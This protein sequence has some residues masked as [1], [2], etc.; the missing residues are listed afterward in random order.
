MDAIMARPLERHLQPYIQ[1][2]VRLVVLL[3]IQKSND[4]D[5]MH[6][7]AEMP[8][9]IQY[10]RERPPCEESPAVKAIPLSTPQALLPR[11]LGLLGA[12]AIGGTAATRLSAVCCV[13]LCTVVTAHSESSVMSEISKHIDVVRSENAERFWK[14]IGPCSRGLLKQLKP[15]FLGEMSRQV[16]VE[17]YGHGCPL[18]Q[19]WR[20]GAIA[21]DSIRSCQK[22]RGSGTK[23]CLRNTGHSLV[24]RIAR[25]RSI[26]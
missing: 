16:G 26:L 10:V 12:P 17:R 23:R 1:N 6:S 24:C 18:L 19:L 13:L 22:T 21:V 4:T 20:K 2:L 25:Y 9:T 15:S 14:T 3:W 11:L 8:E 5:A 7:Y